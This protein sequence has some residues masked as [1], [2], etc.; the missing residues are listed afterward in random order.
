MPL[1]QKFL[2]THWSQNM[3]E[4][5][6]ALSLSR[7]YRAQAVF[8]LSSPDK[9]GCISQKP[10]TGRLEA[11]AEGRRGSHAA[12]IFSLGSADWGELRTAEL[13]WNDSSQ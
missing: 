4:A 5:F 7:I 12:S 11:R 1:L 2:T 3:W 13:P 10:R 6:A 9:W 8:C